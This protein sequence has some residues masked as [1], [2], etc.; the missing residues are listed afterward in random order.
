M[1]SLRA[2]LEDHADTFRTS[3]IDG[4]YSVELNATFMETL[5]GTGNDYPVF[6]LSVLWRMNVCKLETE[7]IIK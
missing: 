6:V 1:R 5:G 4:S 3:L 2:I 7:E